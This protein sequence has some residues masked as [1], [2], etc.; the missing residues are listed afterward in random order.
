MIVSKLKKEKKKNRDINLR[1][2][3]VFSPTLKTVFVLYPHTVL[4]K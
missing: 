3:F 1:Y 2:E 4:S